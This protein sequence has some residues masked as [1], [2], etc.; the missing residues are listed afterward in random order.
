MAWLQ[1]PVVA[2]AVRDSV[3]LTSTLSALHALGFTCIMGG[4][5]FANLGLLGVLFP[6]RPAGEMTAPGSKLIALGLV[7]SLPTGLMLVAPRAVTASHNPFFEL[8]MLLLVTAAIVQFGLQRRASRAMGAVGLTV[9]GS[10]ALAACA[11][12][13]LE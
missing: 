1:S 10:L 11:F 8:K 2:E 3:H 4:A 5:L 12:I 13:L 9:W 6:T 7:I